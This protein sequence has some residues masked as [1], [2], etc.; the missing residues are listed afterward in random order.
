MS[1][2]TLAEEITRFVSQI[3]QITDYEKS[4]L[5]RYLAR[6]KEGK[7]TRDENPKSHFSVYI[8]PYNPKTNEVFI[9]D[10]KKAKQWLAPGGHIDL[11]ELSQQTRVREAK[12]ELGITLDEKEA[13]LFMISV[14]D[15]EERPTQPCREHFDLWY[16][17]ETNGNDFKIDL[18]EFNETRWVNLNEAKK[19]LKEQSNLYALEKLK[20]TIF[21]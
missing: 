17:I 19:L 18:S 10:H 13:P 7:L 14:V 3:D 8:Y 16:L 1:N 21:K 5:P 6:L 12:E 9:V 11:G 20:N 15:I 2:E 4:V